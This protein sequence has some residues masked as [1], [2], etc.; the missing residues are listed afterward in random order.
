MLNTQSTNALTQITIFLVCLLSFASLSRA[1]NHNQLTLAKG[2]YNAG[3][4]AFIKLQCNAC[5]TVTGVNLPAA[6]EMFEVAVELGSK[7]QS[8]TSAELLTAIAN[9]SHSLAKGFPVE[10]IS[11]HGST[12]MPDY[13]DIMTVSELI[14]IVTFLKRHY[15]SAE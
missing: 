1:D 4:N 14:N 7:K 5:H 10:T 13:N 8:K 9:P 15:K 12:R 6:E 3:K 11:S 2:S